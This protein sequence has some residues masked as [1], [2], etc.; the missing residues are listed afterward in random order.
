M[1]PMAVD[2]N[3]VEAIGTSAGAL[4]TA[5]AVIVAAIAFSAER[6]AR[7]AD[8]A[9][10]D[11]LREDVESAQASLVVAGDATADT[12]SGKT[13]VTLSNYSQRPVFDVH[14]SLVLN[15]RP[16]EL[17][18]GRVNGTPVLAVVGP[19]EQRTV[20]L[21]APFGHEQLV[22]AR[23]ELRDSMGLRWRREN[24]GRPQRLLDD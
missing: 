2:W 8:V 20:T 7:R 19:G 1:T 21:N 6:K 22:A 13:R 18:D 15:G 12:G 14:L 11:A 23:L 5:G 4:V 16:V 10:M 9:R 17:P 3:A 24:N